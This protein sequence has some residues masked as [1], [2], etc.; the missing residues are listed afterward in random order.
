MLPTRS[1]G[2]GTGVLVPENE[3]EAGAEV[4]ETELP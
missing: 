4:G 1:A 3:A 2:S